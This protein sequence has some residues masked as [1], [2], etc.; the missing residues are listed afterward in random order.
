MP[1]LLLELLSEE[2]P[3]RMQVRAAADLKRLVGGAL[4]EA[5]L[6]CASIGA[7]VTPRRLTLVADGL[8]ARQPDVREERKGPR[9]DAPEKAI[10]GFLR[11][12]GLD[13]DQVEERETD[14]GV[15]LFAVTARAGRDTREA[16]AD[17]LPDTLKR[18]PWPKSMRWGRRSLRWVRPLR[19]ILCLFDSATVKFVLKDE[20]S[21]EDIVSG[22]TTVGHRFLPPRPFA[23]TGFADYADG[24]RRAHVVLDPAERR[25]TIA[26]GAGK[27]A[28]AEG[29][30]V[31]PD[32][33]LVNEV[34]GLVEWPVPLM[35][36]IDAAFMDLPPEAM[37]AA[38]R[39]HQKYFALEDADG[40]LAPRFVVVAN[41]EAD[42]GGAAIVAGNER[43]LRARLS[44]ARFFWNEDRKRELESWASELDKVVFHARLGMLDHKTER[45]EKLAASIAG[46]V[47]G[48]DV[49]RVRSAS[50]LAKADLVTGM[51]G[52]FPELQGVMGRYYALA[53][54][55]DAEVADAI[56]GHYAPRGPQDCCP[57]APVSVAVALA[58]RI[59]TLVGF[60]SIGERPTG[61][62]DPF[63]LRRAALGVIRLIL[64][65]GLR[66]E[67][68]DVFKEAHEN[69]LSSLMERKL[70]HPSV[71]DAERELGSRFEQWRADEVAR[72][73][74]AFV[75]DRLK[76]HLRDR[77][78]RHDRIAAVFSTTGDDDL[79]RLVARVEALD[80]FLAGEDGGN[81]LTAWRR[82]ANIVRIEE[83]NDGAAYRGRVDGALLHERPERELSEALAASEKEIAGRLAAERYVDAMAALGRLRRPV[84]AFF[85]DVTVNCDDPD[86]RRNRL[87]LLSRI[88]AALE[89]VADFSR[90]EG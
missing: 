34:A 62:K 85:D 70:K 50:R 81:L 19:G 80:E 79:S 59:D 76:V 88:G 11:S 3:A 89:S 23:V 41:I 43:V 73:L 69:Y 2:I 56:A 29:L 10:A 83:K 21:L 48:A 58:D 45:M 44:D 16:L 72:E 65:N 75:A 14:K 68:R 49:D 38:I 77:G 71:G 64:E 84:D 18:L 6:P 40:A 61:S 26:E 55:E 66:L 17:V 42:D 20:S 5:G 35:G 13:R 15:F 22:N 63:A 87:C 33:A 90:I 12:A 52:E 31:V 30:K 8:P 1:E 67:L 47:P 57:T 54:G 46:R 24:L 51:V 32:D 82:A 7:F 39:T 53:D 4:D 37:T 9:A 27:L 60:F 86:L 25:R 78:I 28:A 36:R 74:M